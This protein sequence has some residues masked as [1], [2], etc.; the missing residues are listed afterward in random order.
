MRSVITAMLAFAV[1]QAGQPP[2]VLVN[3]I[4]LPGV[5]GRIDHL[6]FDSERA[7]L[8]VAALGNNSVEVLDTR[9]A[10]PLRHLAGFQEPQGIAYIAD[11]HA[12]AIANGQGP[13]VQMIDA[14]DF[15]AVRTITLGDD[16]DNV[17]YDGAATR[18]YVGYGGGALAAIDSADG[19]V[20]GRV[21]LGGH[22]ESFQ[23]E[24]GGPRIFVNVPSA[25]HIAVVDRQ[26]LRVAA[27]WPVSSAK[28]NYPMALDEEGKRLF[29]GCR[30]PAVVLVY[31][32]TSGKQEATFPIVGDTDDL[33]Y[34]AAR[35]RLYVTGGDGFLDVFQTEGGKY[36]RLGRIA[37]G[38]GARTSLFVPQQSRL[39][40][41]IPHRGTQHAAVQAFEAK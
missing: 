22:P 40:V 25:G 33:F 13:G 4:E 8:F 19:K 37:T 20:A 12:V 7:H 5:E 14:V 6:A 11:A 36:D 39:Y 35:K 9:T 1:V 17:R 29:I 10:K 32:T 27:T 16:S 31:D 41:A 26:S 18:F 34:D 2:M 30:R 21:S 15:H 38:A 28:A 23:L 24:S 3:T